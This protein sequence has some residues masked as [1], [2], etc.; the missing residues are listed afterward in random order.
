MR[1]ILIVDD[2]PV[3]R[4]L[5]VRYVTAAG[6]RA[7]EAATGAEAIRLMDYFADDI[8][9]AVIDQTLEDRKGSELGAEL[10]ALRPGMRTLLI[11][12]ALRDEV[13]SELASRQPIP[14]FLQK[15]FSRE[16]LLD[17]IRQVLAERS[18]GAP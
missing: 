17:M 2:E 4:S 5:L 13:T 1:T 7:L 8:D 3:L 12:G 14:F 16:V 15:P 11:S 18:A 9:L 10:T 6:Y